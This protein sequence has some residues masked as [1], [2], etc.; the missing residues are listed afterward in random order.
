MTRE[1]HRKADEL[2]SQI[3]E[4]ELLIKNAGKALLDGLEIKDY[5]GHTVLMDRHVD[6]VY[7]LK[8]DVFVPNEVE[9]TFPN[10]KLNISKKFLRPA[11]EQ[12]I[13]AWEEEVAQLKSEYEAL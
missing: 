1:T 11:I 6:L 3:K 13:D 5:M 12:Q 2:L 4:K 7:T 9:A 8:A 10:E